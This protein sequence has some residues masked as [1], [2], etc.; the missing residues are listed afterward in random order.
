VINNVDRITHY[1]VQLLASA[2]GYGWC[3]LWY[4]TIRRV[5]TDPIASPNT[6][7]FFIDNE[8]DFAVK[9]G[10]NIEGVRGRR[11]RCCWDYIVQYHTTGPYVENLA[12]TASSSSSMINDRIN[13][14]AWESF[15]HTRHHKL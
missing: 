10:S 8:P 5:T 15:C 11:R 6:V 14:V 9:R 7:E 4:N 1:C 2:A 13:D 3:I 12:A